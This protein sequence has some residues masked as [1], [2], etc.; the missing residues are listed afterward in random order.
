MGHLANLSEEGI[1]VPAFLNEVC[2]L[3]HMYRA[4]FKDGT[5]HHTLMSILHVSVEAL[6]GLGANNSVSGWRRD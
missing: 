5:A 1:D 6:D 3:S 2:V 4:C